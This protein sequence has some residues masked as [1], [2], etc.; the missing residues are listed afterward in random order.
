MFKILFI[1]IVFM[2]IYFA[3][4]SAK[5]LANNHNNEIYNYLTGMWLTYAILQILLLVRYII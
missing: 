2:W 3:I 4:Q 5:K 1:I